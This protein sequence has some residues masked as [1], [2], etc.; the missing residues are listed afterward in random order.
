M[1]N[2]IETMSRQAWPIIM[3]VL[4]YQLWRWTFVLKRTTMELHLEHSTDRR[5]TMRNRWVCSNLALIFVTSYSLIVTLLMIVEIPPMFIEAKRFPLTHEGGM[6]IVSLLFLG[7]IGVI[8]RCLEVP[9]EHWPYIHRILASYGRR[10][11]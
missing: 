2:V 9:S 7:M 10:G 6:V 11:K 3:I 8:A 4:I 5:S 1:N